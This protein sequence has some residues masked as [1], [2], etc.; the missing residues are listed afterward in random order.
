MQKI[1]YVVCKCFLQILTDDEVLPCVDVRQPRGLHE[2]LWQRDE[3][4][5][6]N[7][8]LFQLGEGAHL[9]RQGGHAIVGHVKS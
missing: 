7:V 1:L 3:R 4:V 9:G 5:V 6:A 2:A 8:H